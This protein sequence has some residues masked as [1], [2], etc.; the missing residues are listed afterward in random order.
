M[1]GLKYT[2]Q[3]AMDRNAVF[4][5]EPKSHEIVTMNSNNDHS[6]YFS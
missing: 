2:V 1:E 4:A 5:L 6:D 3:Q